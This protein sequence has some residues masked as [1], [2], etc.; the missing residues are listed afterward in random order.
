MRNVVEI[1]AG[2]D[3]LF[4]AEV[5][6]W[7][8][9][10][11]GVLNPYNSKSAAIRMR[12]LILKY[13]ETHPRVLLK[14]PQFIEWYR[15]QNMS[16][17]PS[18]KN[19]KRFID[20]YGQSIAAGR[21]GQFQLGVMAALLGPIDVYE[22]TK[23]T[24]RYHFTVYG[25]GNERYTSPAPKRIGI[26]RTPDGQY[27]ALH[28]LK[29]ENALRHITAPGRIHSPYNRGGHHGGGHN[30][31][32]RQMYENHWKKMAIVRSM[33]RMHYHHFDHH[34]V[35]HVPLHVLVDA[36]NRL[37]QRRENA[38]P[39]EELKQNW[40]T[41]EVESHVAAALHRAHSYPDGKAS[42]ARPWA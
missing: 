32:I 28:P 33:Q 4:K 15:R 42:P 1:E 2:D 21:G 22:G 30:D 35:R 37:Y 9:E 14:D 27:H 12:M 40:K 10:K 34:N 36:R 38:P 13:V 11:K 19:A 16:S 26:L 23:Q 25:V 18:E 8:Y 20:E 41:A 24:Q 31:H 29:P 17:A 39:D 5:Q 3:N 6:G 7:V